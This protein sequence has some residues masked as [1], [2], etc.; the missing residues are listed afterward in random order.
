GQPLNTL[1]AL[2]SYTFSGGFGVEAN[3]LV[4][5]KM[6]NDYQGYLVIPT[7]YEIDASIFYKWEHWT[8]RLELTNLTNQH[9][10]EPSDATYAFQGIVSE[11]AFQAFGTLK[12]SF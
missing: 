10:W 5:S 12:Y 9:N 2:A 7:Q 4:T 8:A 11:A 1:N 3:A 6:N